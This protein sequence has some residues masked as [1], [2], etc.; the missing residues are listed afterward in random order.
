ME[1]NAPPG[2]HAVLSGLWDIQDDIDRVATLPDEAMELLKDFAA[3]SVTDGS[4]I[5][6]SPCVWLDT[7][8]R[9]CRFYNDRPA[10]CR[11]FEMGGR[12]CQ[13]WRQKYEV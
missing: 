7:G 13:S 6:D 8:T 12:W 9:K 5:G 11:D 4:M 3:S 10:I 2:Y 1:Q